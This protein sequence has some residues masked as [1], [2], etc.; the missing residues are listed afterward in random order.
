[1]QFERRVVRLLGN[2]SKLDLEPSG[3]GI[4]FGSPF[5]PYVDMVPSHQKNNKTKNTLS[6]SKCSKQKTRFFDTGLEI[7]RPRRFANPNRRASEALLG[8]PR[9]QAALANDGLHLRN[10]S[11]HEM[12]LRRSL[13]IN[14]S[15]GCSWHCILYL[16]LQGRK[17]L[18][19][20]EDMG[21]HRW[22]KEPTQCCIAGAWIW[23]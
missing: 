12:L 3:L 6:A 14:Q 18:P 16:I 8:A 11:G 23:T 5:K 2:V 21:H 17:L 9:H 15:S 22:E 1:M 4:P 20:T 19:K 7:A 10:G 13:C